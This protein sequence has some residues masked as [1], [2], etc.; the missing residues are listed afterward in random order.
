LAV[1]GG[2]KGSGSEMIRDSPPLLSATLR[3]MQ[4]RRTARRAGE[5][6][7]AVLAGSLPTPASADAAA[8]RVPP[9]PLAKAV[10][11]VRPTTMSDA[12]PGASPVRA[13][14]RLRGLPAGQVRFLVGTLVAG[15]GNQEVLAFGNKIT[16]GEPGGP[17]TTQLWNGINIVRGRPD[18]AVQLRLFV[19][20]PRSG[21]LDCSLRGYV[22]SHVGRPGAK[23]ALRGGWLVDLG[24]AGRAPSAV[25]RILS[26]RRNLL[27]PL[28]GH[29]LTLRGIQGYVPTTRARSLRVTGDVYLTE[30]HRTGDFF[31]PLGPRYPAYGIAAASTWLLATPRPGSGCGARSSRPVLTVIDSAVHHTRAENTLRVPVA[32][33]RCAPWS[34]AVRARTVGGSSPYVISLSA[35]YSAVTVSALRS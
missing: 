27:V 20:I 17:I 22:T 5:L 21:A 29:A 4:Q 34:V 10:A 1:F 16:C 2:F 31:C 8:A 12:G 33:R 28:T 7:L 30:C 11:T 18:V 25:Q 14:L 13:S 23:A 15:A 26:A 3:H 19:T 9:P 24:S 35:T 6:L 32:G